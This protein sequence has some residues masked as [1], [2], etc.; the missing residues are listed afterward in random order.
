[1]ASIVL[2]VVGGLAVDR[3]LDRSPVFT[4]I[5]VALGMAAAGYQLYELA[6]I[7]R[8]DKSAGP[9]ARRIQNVPAPHRDRDGNKGQR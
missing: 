7:G 2:S 9:I 4:L 8:P 1:V 3:W 6:Q 5:G